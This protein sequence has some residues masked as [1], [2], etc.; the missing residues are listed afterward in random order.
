ML[1]HFA[2]KSDFQIGHHAGVFLFPGANNAEAVLNGRRSRLFRIMLRGVVRGGGVVVALN[3]I[4]KDRRH[5]FVGL[6]ARLR[7]LDL[8]GLGGGGDGIDGSAEDVA[9]H[10]FVDLA[11][12]LHQLGQ[13]RAVLE[14]VEQI[15]A[16]GIRQ[17]QARRNRR[18]AGGARLALGL[19]FF[20]QFGRGGGLARGQFLVVF[21]GRGPIHD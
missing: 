8:D 5:R 10:V 2:V 9:S 4:H 21:V 1:A 6:H 7:T 11:A 15:D 14:L 3:D 17:F 19:I 20:R 16:A 12:T 13:F 18:S